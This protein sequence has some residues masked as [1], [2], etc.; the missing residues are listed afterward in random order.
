MKIAIAGTGY[1]GLSNAI[2]LAQH[3]EVV[4]LDI[5]PEKVAMLNR[6]ESP[7]VDAEIEDYLRNKPLNL[8]ATLDKQEAYEGADFIIIATPTDYDPETNYFNT[9][10]VEAVIKDVLAINPKAVMVIKSTIPVGFTA[11]ARAQYRCDNLIFSPE[12]LREGRA[13]YDNLYPSRIIVGERSKRAETFA[14]LLKEGAIKQ[15]IP[16]LFTDSTEAEAIKLFANTYLAMRVAFFNELDTYAAT[17]GLD[18]KQII[19]GVCL[20]PRIGSHYNNPSFGY[21]GYCLPKDTKQLLANYRDVPQNLIH[22]IVESNTTRKDF[23]ADSIIRKNPKVVGVYRLIMKAGSDNFRAS[24]IQGIMKRIKAK[25]IEVIVY[26]PVLHEKEFFHSRVVN[27]L[28]QF[29]READVIV[30]NRI[31]DDIRD[32]VNKVYSRDLF[33]SD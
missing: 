16:V 30:A 19:D 11:K 25:G 26:E 4:A 9:G 5:V 27:D 12:F 31:T 21:G 23:I 32:V 14:G 28:A 33:G 22:A 29:K 17:H 13:L 1:V 15:D 8:R 10:S 3:H 7:I 18:T 24:S 2:L 20:D 6:K